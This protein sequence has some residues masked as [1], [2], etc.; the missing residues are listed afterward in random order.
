[1]AGIA[2]LLLAFVPSC[3][4]LISFCWGIGEDLVQIPVLV[5]FVQLGGG[6]A[7][8]LADEFADRDEFFGSMSAPL[9]LLPGRQ[10]IRSLA[11]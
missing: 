7:A 6:G 1:V 5:E 3:C 10:Q 8:Q 4:F 2:V 9:F 11:S